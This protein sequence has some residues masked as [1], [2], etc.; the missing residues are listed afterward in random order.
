L[1][2]YGWET[3]RRNR[4]AE[5]QIAYIDPFSGGTESTGIST[6]KQAGYFV[7]TI[8]AASSVRGQKRINY[9]TIDRR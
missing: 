6:Q 7:D 9:A 3:F 1:V 2:G 5:T 4:G 8:N